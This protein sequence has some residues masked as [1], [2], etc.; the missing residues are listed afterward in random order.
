MGVQLAI[1]LV[2]RISR[3]QVIQILNNLVSNALSYT[4]P[5]GDVSL[6]SMM[7]EMRGVAHVGVEVRNSG[8]PRSAVDMPHLFERFYRG[9]SARLAGE[10]GTGLGPAICKEITERH[11]GWIEVES[12]EPRG[13]AFTVW[14]PATGP[15]AV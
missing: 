9:R 2:I 12:A 15:S 8:P 13:A 1:P 4:P 5:G 10:A 3:E 7:Q 14:P 6:S 11:L